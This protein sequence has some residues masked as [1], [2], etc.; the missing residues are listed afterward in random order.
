[1]KDFIKLLS[2]L[3]SVMLSAILLGLPLLCGLAYGL[4]WSDGVRRVLLLLTS[5]EFIVFVVVLYLA[6]REKI[7]ECIKD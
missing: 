4:W 1:M 6:A 3:G 7:D 5:M 2:V